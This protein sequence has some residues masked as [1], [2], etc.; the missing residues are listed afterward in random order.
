MPLKLE[1]KH[2]TFET[3]IKSK[4]IKSSLKNKKEISTKRPLH[5]LLMDFFSPNQVSSL[6]DQQCGLIIVNDYS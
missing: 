2:E 6:S 3:C 5:I 1:E 4:H